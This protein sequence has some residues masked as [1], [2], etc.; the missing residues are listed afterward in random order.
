VVIAAIVRHEDPAFAETQA[1]LDGLQE[2]R[3]EMAWYGSSPKGEL[4]I[5]CA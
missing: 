3:S 4:E 2:G 1:R 5:G